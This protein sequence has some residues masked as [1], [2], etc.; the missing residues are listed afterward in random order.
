MNF[1][2]KKPGNVQGKR[3]NKRFNVLKK[4]LLEVWGM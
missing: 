2:K 3:I 4:K 1:L